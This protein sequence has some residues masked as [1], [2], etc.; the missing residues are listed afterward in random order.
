[1]QERG[2]IMARFADLVEQHADELASLESLDAGKHPA[3]TKAVDIGNAAGSLRY[4]AGAADKIHGETLKMRGQFQGYT[5]REPLGVAGVIIPWNFPSTMFAIKVAPAL[6]AGCT[7]VVK[8]AEQ[9][10]LSA[11]YFAHLAK[12]AGVPDGVVNVVPGFG[13]TAGAALA[14]HMDVDMV[15]TYRDDISRGEAISLLL[16]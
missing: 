14:S 2:R 3:V 4:F 1:M 5:L 9:T 10:P 16:T 12:R 8:P 13:A 7:M 11:L 15:S 6:A